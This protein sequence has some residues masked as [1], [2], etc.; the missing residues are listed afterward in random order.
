MT[1]RMAFTR[2]A[3][4]SMGCGSTEIAPARMAAR[5]ESITGG[6]T[7]GWRLCHPE[8]SRGTWVVGFPRFSSASSGN[9]DR[10]GPSTTLPRNS[11]CL[12]G[13]YE[14]IAEL[15]GTFFHLFEDAV[16]VP[17]VIVIGARVEVRALLLEG[18]IDH[19]G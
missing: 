19:P 3:N 17:F 10:P 13:L 15:S 9:P 8:R 6:V 12:C 14:L 16:G 4:G 2:R 5:R 1:R 18:E 11:Q 7:R